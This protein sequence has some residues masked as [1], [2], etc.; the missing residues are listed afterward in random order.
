M[1]TDAERNGAQWAQKSDTRITRVGKWIRLTRIDEL[2]QIFNVLKGEMSFIG[3]RP[4]RPEFNNHLEREIPYYQ[5]RHLLTPG[6]TGWAQ[7]KYPY[8]ASIEDAIEK[9]QYELYY[10]KNYSFKLDM[11]IILNTIKIVL[12]GKGR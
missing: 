2:P 4:E 3:P 6:I 11:I 10:I 8:G 12:F 1:S 7:V 9:L 5:L